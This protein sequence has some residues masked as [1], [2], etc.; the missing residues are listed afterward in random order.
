M[1][2]GR[3]STDGPAPP[4][5]FDRLVA[6]LLPIILIAAGCGHAVLQERLMAELKGLPLTMTSFEFGCC[7][8]MSL[9]Y[10]LFVR[11]DPT[12]VP[13]K[14]LLGISLLV[15]GS[16]V[17]GNVAL[18]W[19]SYPV[20]VVVKSCKL[21]PTMAL[22]R[23]ILR[24]RRDYPLHD[25]IAAVLLCAGL[26]GFT[27]ADSTGKGGRSSSP[28]GVG[29]LLFAV[30]C[31]AVQVLLA[32]RTLTGFPH[33][34]AMH[35]MVYTN[36]FAFLAVLAG[37][38]AWGEVERLPASLPWVELVLYGGTSW[39]GVA[40]FMALTRLWGA[41]VAV[42]ATSLRKLLTIV[43]SFVL[44]P[45]PFKASFAVSGAAIIGGVWLHSYGRRCAKASEE[46]G[47][48]KEG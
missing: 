16:L 44:F 25:Q 3:M 7:S 18:T 39:V 27:L 1:T 4:S 30:S 17:S 29:V 6:P 9:S 26:V 31:D 41:T 28:F 14:P 36:G 5:L 15:L 19:V 32:E 35:V 37:I 24:P 10:L 38:F 46:S 40:C 22:G 20:K 33:L 2:A 21:L 8:L 23:L 13:L 47:R 34:T 12:D 11:A 45:K 48:E 42:I 43:L